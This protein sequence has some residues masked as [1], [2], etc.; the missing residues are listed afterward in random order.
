MMVKKFISEQLEGIDTPIKKKGLFSNWFKSGKL[1]VII[2]YE[3]N[4]YKEFFKSFPKSYFF[5][6]KI[7]VTL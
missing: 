4:S 7:K 2:V 5:D 1:R 3:D 6:I